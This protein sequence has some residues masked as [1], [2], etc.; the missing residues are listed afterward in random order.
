LALEEGKLLGESE[1][2]N[3]DYGSPEIDR[4]EFEGLPG[5]IPTAPTSSPLFFLNFVQ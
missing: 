3:V 4:C 2:A 5:S 1:M